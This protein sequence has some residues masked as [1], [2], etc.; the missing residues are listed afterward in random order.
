MRQR[1][2]SPRLWRFRQRAAK[3]LWIDRGSQLER[4][5]FARARRAHRRCDSFGVSD[6]SPDSA[7]ADF[8]W[9]PVLTRAKRSSPDPCSE[10]IRVF[11]RRNHR[12]T[13]GGLSTFRTRRSQSS[14]HPFVGR[15]CPS[16]P[17][18]VPDSCRPECPGRLR[19]PFLSALASDLEKRAWLR[20]PLRVR[21]RGL[22]RLVPE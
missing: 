6:L 3:E 19:N 13:A 18:L 12:E 11:L 14:R 2:E 7:A 10:P 4:K 20:V 21:N 22:L 9:H 8:E 15:A 5:Q 17:T 16:D 1:R